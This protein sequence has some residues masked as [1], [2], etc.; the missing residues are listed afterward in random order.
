MAL[1]HDHINIQQVHRENK[2]K[3]EERYDAHFRVKMFS[4]VDFF[5]VEGRNSLVEAGEILKQKTAQILKINVIVQ[6]MSMR[7]PKISLKTCRS[8]WLT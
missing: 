1:L 7:N 4:N 6:S 2:K 5:E 8:C 3:T